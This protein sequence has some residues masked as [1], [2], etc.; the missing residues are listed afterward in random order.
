[1]TQTLNDLHLPYIETSLTF[2]CFTQKSYTVL[3]VFS[4]TIDRVIE[5]KT[6]KSASKIINLPT[7]AHKHFN[8]PYTKTFHLLYMVATSL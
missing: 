3:K 5:T 4:V 2:T 6:L 7:Y 1:M 8:L